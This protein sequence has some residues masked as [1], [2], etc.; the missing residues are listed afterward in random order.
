MQKYEEAC[1]EAASILI[2]NWSDM[3]MAIELGFSEKNKKFNA[4]G[5]QEIEALKHL[6]GTLGG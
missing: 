4:E 6:I 5:E 3:N 1:K 2:C